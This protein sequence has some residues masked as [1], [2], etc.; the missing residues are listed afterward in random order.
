MSNHKQ[1]PNE[2][3]SSSKET[4]TGFLW[5]KEAYPNHHD[6]A[7]CFTYDVLPIDSFYTTNQINRKSNVTPAIHLT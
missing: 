2:G 5:I 3:K 1:N 7:C 6:A 4:I